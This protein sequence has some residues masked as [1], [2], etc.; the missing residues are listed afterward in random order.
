MVRCG[1]G[2][3]ALSAFRTIVWRCPAASTNFLFYPFLWYSDNQLSPSTCGP[4]TGPGRSQVYGKHGDT[5]RGRGVASQI[6]G[7]HKCLRH[8]A[9]ASYRLCRYRVKSRSRLAAKFNALIGP[10]TSP[11]PFQAPHASRSELTICIEIPGVKKKTILSD[12]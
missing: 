6:A 7:E 10:P 1:V 3:K 8:T 5:C 4:S 12:C 11:L 9:S 2:F